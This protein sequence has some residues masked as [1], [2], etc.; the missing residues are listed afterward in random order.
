M[1]LSI[2]IGQSN[3]NE[4]IMSKEKKTV[5]LKITKCATGQTSKTSV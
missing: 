2:S 4:Y 3:T 5:P 1:D